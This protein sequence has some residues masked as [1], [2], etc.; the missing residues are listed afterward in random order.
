MSTLNA[1]WLDQSRIV[2]VTTFPHPN[3]ISTHKTHILANLAIRMKR[4][5]ILTTTALL[6]S[7]GCLG[8][9]NT[10]N[11]GN[12][13][14]SGNIEDSSKSETNT[15]TTTNLTANTKKGTP[16]ATTETH[17]SQIIES[18]HITSQTTGTAL[19]TMNPSPNTSANNQTDTS[20]NGKAHVS[21][22]DG[23]SRIVVTGTIVGENGC[24]TA[25]LDSVKSTQS[26]LVITIATKRDAPKTAGCTGALVNIEYRCVVRVNAPPESVTVVHRS[27]GDK[28]TITTA[29]RK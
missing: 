1:E 9:G 23:G 25:V 17:T 5:D 28:Q 14:S 16:N 21:F 4:R 8:N 19:N 3:R 12:S 11:N 29:T 13:D 15:T 2:V 18:T 6:V 10:D 7:T 26:G 20:Q 27:V 22:K 24:Q